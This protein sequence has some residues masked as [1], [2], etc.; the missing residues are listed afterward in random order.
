VSDPALCEKLYDV[1]ALYATGR[2]VVALGSYDRNRH[3]AAV[4]RM[5]LR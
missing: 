1:I 3:T 5:S 4:Y 2:E